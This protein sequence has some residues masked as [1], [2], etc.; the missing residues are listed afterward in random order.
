MKFREFAI[1]NFQ[2]SIPLNLLRRVLEVFAY[3]DIRASTEEFGIHESI[4]NVQIQINDVY[5]KE[6]TSYIPY[7]DVYNTLEL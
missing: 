1:M 6:L 5:S 3:H 4:R 7:G 2:S